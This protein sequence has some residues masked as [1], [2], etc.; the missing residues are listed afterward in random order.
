MQKI[1]ITGA[2]GFLGTHL[3]KHLHNNFLVISLFNSNIL[4]HKNAISFDLNNIAA[5]P[6]LLN[7]IKPTVVIH[8][9]AISSIAQCEHNKSQSY[10]INVAASEALA[11]H[12]KKIHATFIFC[13]TDLVFDG[14]TGNYN[15]ED[16]PNPIN[17]YGLQKYEAEKN[18]IAVNEDAIIARL[19]LMIG[20][21]EKGIAGVVAEMQLKNKQ[22]VSMHLF[23]NEYRSPALVED[24]VFGLELLMLKKKS[25]TYHLAGKQKLNRVQIAEYVKTKYNLNKLILIPTTHQ[26]LGITNRPADV[27]MVSSKMYALGY[28]PLPLIDSVNS[29]DT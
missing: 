12:C 26:Q 29:K 23:S 15:E 3:Y 13:S 21:N 6:N 7:L 18:I 4:Q 19:P 28:K 25:G 24:V 5:I 27:S 1:L 2:S 22:G 14:T 8:T 20:E 11:L 10:N 16:I 17:E 9:A